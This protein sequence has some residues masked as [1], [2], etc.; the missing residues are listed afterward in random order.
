MNSSAKIYYVI[1]VVLMI[2]IYLTHPYLW[3]NAFYHFTAL[4]FCLV[5]YSQYLQSKGRFSLFVFV[6]FIITINN[7][8]D[9]LFFDPTEMDYSE[10]IS[11]FLFAVTAYFNRRKWV[12][13]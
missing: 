8:L 11:A 2:V 9:E 13:K 4:S 5:H 10:I 12:N 3:K 1:S 6:V 7:L